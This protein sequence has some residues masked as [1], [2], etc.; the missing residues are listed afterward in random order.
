MIRRQCLGVLVERDSIVD[1]FLYL[2]DLM[3]EARRG[4]S[5]PVNLDMPMYYVL[6]TQE[7]AQLVSDILTIVDKVVFGDI[8]QV[9]TEGEDLD[10]L[11][12]ELEEV[13]DGED[14]VVLTIHCERMIG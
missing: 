10:R 9:C 5:Y 14:I 1:D 13:A 3:E 11:V 12:S 6:L 7:D 4:Y 2:S 8:T